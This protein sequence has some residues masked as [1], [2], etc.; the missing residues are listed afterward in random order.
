MVVGFDGGAARARCEARGSNGG[1]GGDG[2]GGGGGG[3][4]GD[5]GD[6]GGGKRRGGA[7]GA[8]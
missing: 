2:G 1:D 3:D 8:S 4:G 6:G 5:G 7:V